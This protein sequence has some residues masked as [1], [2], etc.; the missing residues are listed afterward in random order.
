MRISFIT[1]I[2]LVLCLSLRAQTLTSFPK[3]P[4]EFVKELDRFMTAGRAD[5]NIEAIA[6]FKKMQKEGKISNTLIESMVT[7]CNAMLSRTMS[8]APYYYNYINAVMN[9]AASGQAESNFIEWNRILTE[10]IKNQKKGDNNQFL[11]FIEF[12]NNF[13]QQNTL[14]STNAKTWKVDANSYRLLYEDQKPLVR[15]STTNLIGATTGD[16]IYVHETSGDYFPLETRWAGKSGKVDWARSGLD[17][18]KVFCTFNN[19]SVNV[20]GF[21]YVV[22]TVTFY[23]KDYFNFPLIGRLTDKLVS[24]PS[25][26]SRIT[27]P[28]FDSYTAGITIKDIAPNVSYTGGFSLNGSKVLGSSSMFEKP[29]L[30]FYAADGKT[31]VLSARANSISIKKGEELSADRAEISIYFGTDSIYHPQLSLVYKVAKKE[32]RLLRGETGMGKAKFVDSYHNYEFLT[33]AIYWNVDSPILN[34]KILSGV[35]HKPGIYESVNYFSKDVIRKTQGLAFY[36]PLSVLKKLY[37]KIGYREINVSDFAKALDPNL[38][39]GEVKSL[40][41][42]LVENGFIGYN[43]DQSTIVIKDKALNY[44]LANAK[45]I[46]YDIIQIKSAPKSSNDFINLGNSNIDLKGVFEVPISD[47]AYVFFHPRDSS[48]SLQKDRNMEFDGVVF[49]GRTDLIGEKFKFQYAPFTVELTK[50]DTMRL[51]LPDSSN[52]TDLM[53]RPILVPMKSKV[54]GIKGLLEIDA[55]INKSGRSRLTQFPKL[56]SRDKSFVYYDDPEVAKG[57]YGR[58]SFF[59][60]IEPFQLDSLNNF[61]P[62][63]INWSGK[64]VSG[65]IFPEID[66]SIHLQRD[67]SLGFKSET[68]PEGYDLYGGKGKYY[69]KYELN[70]SGLQ[71]SGRITHSTAEFKADDVRLYPDSLRATTD[72]FAIAKTFE[73]V[74]TPA[75]LGVSDMIFWRPAN[76]S[77]FIS[78]LNKDLPFA[79][80]DDGFTTFKGDLLLTDKGLNGNGTLDWNEATLASNQFVFKTMDLAADTASLNIKTTGDKVTFKTPDVSAKVDFKTRIGE[81]VSNQKNIPTDFSYN[82]YTTAI[83]EFKWFMDQ[84]I[85]DFKAPQDGPGEYFTSTKKEQQ[86]LNFLGKRATY[87]LVSSLLRVE[88]VPEI[89]VADALVIPDSGVVI[90]EEEARMH[91][92]RNAVIV[93]DTINKNHTFENCVVDIFSKTELKAVGDYTYT[94]KD[95]KQTVNFGDISC[96]LDKE[97]KKRKQVDVYRLEARAIIDE[98]Q[99]FVLYPDVKFNGEINILAV[100]PTIRLKGYS[101]IELKYPKAVTDDFFIDQD[102]NRDTLGLRYDTTVRNANGNL[103]SAGIHLSP[104]PE[105]PTMYATLLSPKLDN[106]DLTIFQATGILAQEPNGEY[107]FGDEKRIREKAI[108]GN[109][110]RYRDVNGAINAEGKINL[111]VN[112]GVIKTISAGRIET[113]LDSGIFKFN[114]SLGID[115]RLDDKIQDRMEFF[116]VGDNAD[117]KDISYESEAQKKAISDLMDE[118]DDRKLLEDFNQS[119]AFVKRPKGLTHNMVFSDVNFVF[120]KEDLSL[121]SVGKLGVAMIGK[122]VINKKLEGYIEFQ[123]KEGGDVL[124]IYLQTG[125]KDWFYFEYRPGTLNILSSYNDV[126]KLI[127]ATSPDKRKIKGDNNRFYYYTLGSSLNREDFVSYMKDKES[128]VVRARPEPRI[129]V[130]EPV[131]LPLDSLMP[132]DSTN[133]P[134]SLG[135]QLQ[136]EDPYKKNKSR[137]RKGVDQDGANDEKV[138]P[139]PVIEKSKK[140][141]SKKAAE[142]EMD[143][144]QDPSSNLK[145]RQKEMEQMRQQGDGILSGPPPDRNKPAIEPLPIKEDSSSIREDLK[146]KVV[147]KEDSN[148]TPDVQKPSPKIPDSI[149]PIIEPVTTDSAAKLPTTQPQ[150]V[151]PEPVKADSI[152]AQENVAP[153]ERKQELAPPVEEVKPAPVQPEPLKENSVVPNEEPKPEVPAKEDLKTEPVQPELLKEEPKLEA[154]PTEE[155]KPKPLEEKPIAPI[156]EPKQEVLPSEEVKPTPEL[157]KENLKQETAPPV[158]EVKPE[159]IQPAPPKDDANLPVGDVKPTEPEPPISLPD[160]EPFKTDT[161]VPQPQTIPS[162]T[163]PK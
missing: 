89:R 132:N 105:A 7:P 10:V 95:L 129:E 18:S 8:P 93:A 154:I 21:G 2:G 104:N 42:S 142:E 62:D 6:A 140:K 131:E 100:N 3:D 149:A 96:K 118:K 161:I 130:S 70:Y 92:L 146:E 136:M 35:G 113:K 121:R 36:E 82:Q 157:P 80:Y 126:N 59:F 102:V 76:D 124:T 137:N 88:Q 13:F 156:E 56:Y 54:E 31:K 32:M 19:Y 60:E 139:E 38:K 11:K 1:F 83:N 28:R 9:L 97:G 69:G 77:M 150:E 148:F 12:S 25:D 151:M 159:T 152:P 63:I 114:L 133:L 57:A 111:G 163:I 14:Y 134:D 78:M 109:V 72:T 39:D 144:Y 53:G 52:R 115:A 75:V 22:D 103:L 87:N 45:K 91:Q 94:T 4:D 49:A 74:Q 141:K 125:T 90:I 26:S 47:T 65:G 29:M 119:G 158:E 160:T 50:V 37:E 20:T 66:D 58:K 155:A 135:H 84:K 34:L 5:K 46:D 61:N 27:Y 55:P 68:P 67:G 79:M 24:G 81:F 33:D 17:P 30:T 43:E 108:Q 40:L 48:V 106:K 128:G 71:G 117:Q 153:Q 107:L 99:N 145:E 116:M 98:K 138:I 123:Y 110:L 86:G 41:Y 15:F 101:K 16:T 127:T 162:D 73:G 85:L 122:K 143:Y 147:P 44:V 51:Y 64:L 23:Y 120:D 112:L